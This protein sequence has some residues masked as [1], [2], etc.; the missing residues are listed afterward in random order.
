MNN[1]DRILKQT[2]ISAAG[3]LTQSNAWKVLRYLEHKIEINDH[4]QGS[5]RV[6]IDGR[7]E[8]IEDNKYTIRDK[9]PVAV[10]VRV[11]NKRAY[12]LNLKR[13]TRTRD[14]PVEMAL[15]TVRALNE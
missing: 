3:I 9:L 8:G 5:K 12:V 2:H 13:L 7:T 4:L 14:V 15:A 10:A 6:L 11:D 1:G